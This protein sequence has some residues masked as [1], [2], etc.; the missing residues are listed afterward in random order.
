MEGVASI[1][2]SNFTQWDLDFIGFTE[3]IN[4]NLVV[5]SDVIIGVIDAGIWLDSPSFGD[6]GFGPPKKIESCL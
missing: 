4:W 5:E 1:K 6:G 2:P 3:T